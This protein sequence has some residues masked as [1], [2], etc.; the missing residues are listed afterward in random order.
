M[1]GYEVGQ[2]ILRLEQ[3]DDEMR[4]YLMTIAEVGNGYVV[5]TD[6]RTH[7]YDD[8]GIGIPMMQDIADMIRA[9]DVGYVVI[10]DEDEE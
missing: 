7:T 1:A 2:E 9:S 8:L 3:V 6:G 10:D 5:D 4:M